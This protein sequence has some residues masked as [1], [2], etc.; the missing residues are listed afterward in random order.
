MCLPALSYVCVC[1]CVS[2]S[3]DFLQDAGANAD[4]FSELLTLNLKK[5]EKVSLPVRSLICPS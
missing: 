2:H 3:K 1:V 5:L 4:H